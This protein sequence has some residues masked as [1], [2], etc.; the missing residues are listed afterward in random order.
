LIVPLC[1]VDEIA[2]VEIMI[3]KRFNIALLDII[4]DGKGLIVFAFE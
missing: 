2:I 1:D 3:N 4:S